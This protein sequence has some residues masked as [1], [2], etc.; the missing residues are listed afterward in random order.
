MIMFSPIL[1]LIFTALFSSIYLLRCLLSPLSAIPGP[2]LAKYTSWI[3]KWHEFRANRTRYIHS[4]H[5]LYGP[6]VRI[7]PNEVAFTSQAALKEIYCSSGSGYDKT[8]F[9]DLFKV[10]G[11]R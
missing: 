7:A 9:Y 8:E 2:A 1:G 6:V 4:L 11:R 3:L 10:Y 5:L